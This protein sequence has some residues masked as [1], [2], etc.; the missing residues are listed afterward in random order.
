MR[1]A[2][3]KLQGFEAPAG[4]WESELLA[5]RLPDYQSS[6]LD[7]LCLAGEATWARLTPRRPRVN[8]EGEAIATTTAATRATPV[9][10]A[11]RQD[12]GTLLSATRGIGRGW[13]VEAGTAPSTGAAAEVLATLQA[14]GA[15]FFDE[16][17]TSTRRLATDV[18]Q[19]LRELIG[20]GWVTSDGFQGLREI[21]GGRKGGAGG[22]RDRWRR[23]RRA[24]AY[25]HGLFLGGGPPG[26]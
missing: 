4:A 24:S 16:L 7:E 15:L 10:L 21:A 26:R 11:L 5:A 22:R 17:V 25:A 1:Q 23:A 12:L 2:L 8:E 9:T 20:G 19:G 18:E 13:G 3:T 6:W 14:R